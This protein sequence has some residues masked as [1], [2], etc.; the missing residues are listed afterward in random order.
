VLEN[1]LGEMSSAWTRI[2]AEVGRSTRVCAY[3]RAG[4]A[5][6]DDVDGPQDGIA[7]ASDL[8]ALLASA[9]ERG[10]FVLVGHSAGGPYVM[11]YAARYPDEVAG[12][13]LLDSMSPDEFT[14]LPGFADEQSMM[15]RGLGV[16]PSLAR[17]GVASMLPTSVWSSQPEPAASQVQAFASSPRGMRNMRDEQSMY[18]IVF[19]QAKQ[20]NSLGDKPLV[21]VTATES[22]DRDEAWS[23]LQDRLAALSTD[24]QHR[25]AD[26]T[27]AGVV[28]D[29][30][31]FAP[32]V[33]AILDVVEAIRTGEPVVAR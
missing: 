29:T 4:Q 28:D 30:V 25:V 24:S 22:L 1:G 21:V 17:L 8:H 15:R 16:L 2:I 12:M 27:H 23:D 32:S 10:P 7:I 18:P 6:S 11:T 3:D 33:V 14:D 19:E 31:T 13:V 9:G 5:W 26:A 20:L